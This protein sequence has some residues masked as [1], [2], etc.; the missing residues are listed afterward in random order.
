MDNWV[1]IIDESPE[2]TIEGVEIAGGHIAV[3][4][5]K[6]AISIFTHTQWMDK[7]VREVPLPP[8]ELLQD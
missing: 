4:K 2:M 5:L 1:T 8:W 3:S 7:A 6:D